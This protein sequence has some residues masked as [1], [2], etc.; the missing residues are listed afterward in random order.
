MDEL[1]RAVEATLFASAEPLTV[2]EIAE[3]VGEGDVEFALGQLVQH[4]EGRGID[5]VE[6][7]GRWHFQTAP[8]LA[9]LLRRTREEPRRLSRALPGRRAIAQQSTADT[10]N[11]ARMRVETPTDRPSRATCSN[12]PVVSGK[13]AAP[14]MKATGKEARPDAR[15]IQRGRSGWI[16]AR[17]VATAPARSAHSKPTKCAKTSP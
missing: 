10:T 15:P 14:V 6:R 11:V 9:H 7:G 16:R 4:Y 12:V 17:P 5:L 13:R 8:D 3:H 1:A 2:E